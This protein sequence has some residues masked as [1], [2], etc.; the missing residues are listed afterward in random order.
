M[1]MN[2]KQQFFRIGL[3]LF[4]LGLVVSLFPLALLTPSAA[5]AEQLVPLQVATDGTS[6]A[7]ELIKDSTPISCQVGKATY[8]KTR[9]LSS[10]DGGNNFV[11]RGQEFNGN[12]M[13][14]AFAFVDARSVYIL[15]ADPTERGNISL[16]SPISYSI[17]FSSNA[18]ETWEK[19]YQST[20]TDFGGGCDL[21]GSIQIQTLAGRFT[22][23]D[24]VGVTY[25]SRLGGSGGSDYT[26]LVSVDGAHT[27]NLVGTERTT[28]PFNYYYTPEGLV[29]FNGLDKNILE[30]SSDGGKSWQALNFPDYNPQITGCGGPS[31]ATTVLAQSTNTPGHLFIFSRVVIWFSPADAQSQ[32]LKIFHSTDNGRTW[33]VI[34]TGLST[35]A[36]SEFAP[37][38]VTAL[39]NDKNPVTLNVPDLD[40][41]TTVPVK[42]NNASNSSY[43]PQTGHTISAS[44][45]NFYDTHGG[46]AQ[47]GYPKT[48]PFRELNPSDGKVYLVQYFERGRLEYHPELAGTP[49]EVELGLLG[50]QL[51]Q[52]RRASGE[53]A[54]NHFDDAHYSGGIYFAQTEHNLR[55]GFKNYWLQH[56]GLAIYGYPISEEFEEVNP[57]D[58]KTYVVQYFERN[59]FEYHPENKGTQYEVLLGLL[60]NSLLKEKGWLQ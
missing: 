40:K 7:Y 48:E 42:A 23:V 5:H 41:F 51:T 18:G 35:L 27:F 50:N 20:L 55:N 3:R 11:E 36:I 13:S 44:I 28:Y 56:G 58:G 26:H 52:A 38:T 1:N 15:V 37:T 49:Y 47:F 54:F 39:D 14:V 34:A 60:G 45:K 53:G 8:S 59:R 46:L 6:Q 22:P 33:Q 32:T 10:N 4:L 17:Y 16:G 2:M 25:T 24:V 43:F 29:K 12:I 9:L 30:L 21:Y 57:D 31:C 19:R